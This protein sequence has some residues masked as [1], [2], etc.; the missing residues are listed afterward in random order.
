MST[1]NIDRKDDRLALPPILYLYNVYKIE[2]VALFYSS[3][4]RG[5]PLICN[6]VKKDTHI[7]VNKIMWTI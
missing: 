2:P 4:S 6:I 5:T 7:K 1:F 3:R